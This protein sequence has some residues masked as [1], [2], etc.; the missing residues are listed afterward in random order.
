AMCRVALSQA[1]VGTGDLDGALP[2]LRRAEDLNAELR[3]EVIAADLLA[4]RARVF[5]ARGQYRRAVDFLE[6][7]IERLAG[8]ADNPRFSEFQATLARLELRAG[9]PRVAHDRLKP[10]LPKTE[11][12]EDGLQRMRGH[13]WLP[14]TPP[15][16]GQ[17]GPAQPSP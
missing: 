15:A 7:A 1:L 17:P 9:R 12:G 10:L 14:E 16:P 8:G 5:S 11:A 4:L 3:M 6:R 2:S 13:Y